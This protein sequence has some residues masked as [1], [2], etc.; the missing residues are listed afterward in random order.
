MTMDKFE[1]SHISLCRFKREKNSPFEAGIII[2]DGACIIDSSFKVVKPPIWNYWM[3][4]S[5]L[6]FAFPS[7][8]LNELVLKNQK[9]KMPRELAES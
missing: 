2:N 1:L 4:D 9:F 3:V 6:S 7:I 5:L 8:D